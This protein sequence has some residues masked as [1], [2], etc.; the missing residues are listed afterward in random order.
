MFENIPRISL[1]TLPTPLEE[2]PALAKHL[3]LKS[4][5]IKRDDMTGL[6][7][8]GNKVRKLEFELAAAL[9]VGCDTVITVGA[10]QSNHARM[11]A[12]AC[13]KTGLDIKLVLGGDDVDELK[14]NLLLDAL[15]GADIR[16]IVGSCDEE[17]LNREM[18][19]WS[20]ELTAAGKK[21]YTIIMGA[22]TPLG[23]IG[24]VAAMKEIADQF[25]DLPVQVVLTVSSCGMYAGVALG[26]AIYMPKAK[27]LGISVSH[28]K[29]FIE[30]RTRE[31]MTESCR[32]LG[33]D[34]AYSETKL[35]IYDEYYDRYAVPVKGAEEASVVCANLEAMIL[36]QVYTG[37]AMYGLFELARTGKLNREVPVIFTHSGGMPAVFARAVPAGDNKNFR[38]IWV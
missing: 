32:L 21:P 12:A 7:L 19:N 30:K 33:I 15:Y 31:L 20:D 24:Y 11:T 34:P 26:A 23:A 10:T 35:Q 5:L 8:G 36:D 29:E 6:A 27:I 22:S 28:N 3:G 37:K 14:G 18:Y 13:R 9:E 4:L 16:Y 2:A 17:V 38:R 25:G 1:A